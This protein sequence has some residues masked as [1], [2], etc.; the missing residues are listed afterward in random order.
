MCTLIPALSAPAECLMAKYLGPKEAN[1]LTALSQNLCL[2]AATISTVIY[3]SQFLFLTNSIL[4][5]EC[6][7]ILLNRRRH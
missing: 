7:L 1:L 4:K 3:P 6:Y 2:I 5:F